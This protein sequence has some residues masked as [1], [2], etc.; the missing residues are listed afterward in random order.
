MNAQYS[1][2][3]VEVLDILN[4]TRKADVDKIPKNFIEFLREQSSKTYKSSI[5]HSKP[6]KEANLKSKTKALLGL[7]YLNYWSNDDEK[8][9]FKLKLKENVSIYYIIKKL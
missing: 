7:I 4:Y 3:A 2:A 1:E 6:L 8:R 9:E 5:D